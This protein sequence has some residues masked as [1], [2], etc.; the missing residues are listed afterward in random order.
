MSAMRQAPLVTA[1]MLAFAGNSLLCRLALRTTA[2]DAGSFTGIRLAAGA[3]TLWLIMR[4]TRRAATGS[5]GSAAALFGY[6]AAFSF[7]YVQLPAAAG[8][9]LLFGAVQVSMIGYAVVRGERPSPTKI[10]GIAVAVLGLILLLLPGLAAPSPWHA[11]MML[12]AGVSWGVYSIRGRAPG[13]PTAATAGNFIRAVPFALAL[14]LFT[15]RRVDPAGAFY[16]V[17]SGAAA[18]G[19]GYAVWYAALRG[20]GPT[21]AATIQLSVPVLAGLG[22]VALLGEPL[23]PRLV[24]C[25]VA[26]LGGIA[27]VIGKPQGR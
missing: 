13:D 7:A 20:L 27:L 3:L 23:T 16:A 14:A 2:I 11:A 12:A 15:A 22:G 21:Q 26:I 24:I 9:L 8:A 19:L 18:S 6:A 17:L 25:S 4:F 10:A 1:A 5:W